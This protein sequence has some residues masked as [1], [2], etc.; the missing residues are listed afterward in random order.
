MTLRTKLSLS[1]GLS[2]ALSIVLTLF[3]TWQRVSRFILS[4]E[5]SHFDSIAQTVEDNLLSSYQ[6]YLAAKVRVVLSTKRKMRARTRDARKDLLALEKEIPPSSDRNRL[7][8][9]LLTNHAYERLL[10]TDEQFIISLTTVGEVRALGFPPLKVDA[11]TPN[12][13]QQT[14]TDMLANLSHEG[15]FALWPTRSGSDEPVLLFFLPVDDRAR[16]SGVL[17]DSDRIFVSGLRLGSLFQEAEILRRNRLDAAK[18]N[19]ESVKFYENGLLMLRD[20]QGDVLI[21]RGDESGYLKGR[22][23]SLYEEAKRHR[24]AVASVETEDGEYLCHVAWVHAYRWF[25]VMAAPMEVL[26][27]PSSALVSHLLLAGLVILVVAAL[28]T[29]FMVMHALRPLRKLRD[30]TSELASLDPSSSSSLDAMETM[31][32]QQ[33]DLVRRDELG[34]L[35]RSFASMSQELTKNIRASM[36]AMT[37]QKRM[38]GELNAAKDI[39]MGILPNLNDAPPE[40]GFS[41]AN[42][43]EPAREVGGDLYDSF[44]LHDG[45]KAIVMGDVS[46]KGVPAALFMTMSVT[47]VRYTLRSG[48]DPAEALTRVNALLEEHNPGNMFVT[49]FLALYSPET[50]ELLYANGG[51]CLPYVMDA[52]GHLRQLEHLSGPLVGAMPDVEYL[53][54][55][56]TLSP[57]DTCFLYTDGLTEAMNSEKELYGEERLAACLVAHSKAAPRELQNAVF[58]D[59][60]AFRGDEPPSDDITMLTVCRHIVSDGESE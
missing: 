43:L 26:R 39:Q 48:L 17:M 10:I 8:R 41:V 16:T 6:E 5:E 31:L 59:I 2:V 32:P 40:P 35:A 58:A 38:E 13:K 27:A 19:F 57:G 53:P 42:F 50:G 30:C 54:F 55:K 28:F 33:L 51:H 45:R 21:K 11:K 20:E 22:L 18:N 60:C 36:E 14:L 1:V 15:D 12:V 56:D 34:D 25:F 46:G 23:D 49:L 37:V 47:L 29:A 4:S 44:T 3:L 9:S 24:H 7:S 52:E